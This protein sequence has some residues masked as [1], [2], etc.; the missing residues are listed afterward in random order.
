M[1]DDE[2]LDRR[3]HHGL[4]ALL[5]RLAGRVPDDW[6]TGLRRMLA[7]GDLAQVPDRITGGVAELGVP[8]TAAEVALLREVVRFCWG[9]RE[10]LRVDEVV[11]ADGT[12]ATGHWFAPVPADVLASD[13]AR[14]PPRLDLTGRAEDSLWDLPPGLGDLED[15]SLRLTDAADLALLVERRHTDVRVIARAWRFPSDTDLTD[16]VR[17]VLVEVAP[18]APAWEIVGRIQRTLADRD[19]GAQVEV[20]WA[21]AELTP[22][23]RAALD[24][25]AVFYRAPAA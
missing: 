7:A 12:P 18:S 19:A 21:G 22:Y 9:E 25:A 4:H 8:L 2:S 24:R 1:S 3:F 23:H 13:A 11:I 17:V 14:I 15:L 16:G 5:L 6:L 10:P 20:L